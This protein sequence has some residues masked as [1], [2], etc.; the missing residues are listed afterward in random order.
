MQHIIKL[1][2]HIDEIFVADVIHLISNKKYSCLIIFILKLKVQQIY[3]PIILNSG[4]EDEWAAMTWA[5]EVIH[6]IFVDTPPG[7][8][9]ACTRVCRNCK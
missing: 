8:H 4:S 9:A 2:L 7:E 3:N 5:V 1:R 6:H